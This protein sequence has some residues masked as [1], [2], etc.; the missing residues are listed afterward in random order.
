MHDGFEDIPGHIEE[1]MFDL[2][3]T[4]PPF[5][6]FETD[7]DTLRRF[8]LAVGRQSVDRVVLAIER[9][10]KLAKPGGYIAIVVIDGILNNRSESTFATT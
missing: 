2:C 4:N 7:S 10:I 9:C 6:S 1:G 8:D 5:G 3:I